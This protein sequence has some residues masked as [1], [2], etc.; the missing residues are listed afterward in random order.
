MKI[1]KAHKSETSEF[2]FES[3]F[4]LIFLLGRS[5]EINHWDYKVL[6]V[7]D[8]TVLQVTESSATLKFIADVIIGTSMTQLKHGSITQLYT[9][10]NVL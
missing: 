8:A 10:F 6:Q 3:E 7:N 9:T 1:C 2:E 4:R 5:I